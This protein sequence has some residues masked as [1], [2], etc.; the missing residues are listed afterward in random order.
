MP[1]VIPGWSSEYHARYNYW[2]AHCGGL[3]PEGMLY[4]RDVVRAETDRKAPRWSRRTH[5]DCQNPWW[6]SGLSDR[7]R[8]LKKLPK[9]LPPEEADPEKRRKVMAGIHGTTPEEGHIMILLPEPLGRR[10]QYAKDSEVGTAAITN[11][12]MGF[13]M[14]LRAYEAA[15]ANPYLCAK[16]NIVLNEVQAIADAA[17]RPKPKKRR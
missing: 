10:I 1:Y 3:I 9:H 7:C 15:A 11:I 8:G 4:H 12:E 13:E 5:L 17:A 14:L 16:M 6:Q 2:C